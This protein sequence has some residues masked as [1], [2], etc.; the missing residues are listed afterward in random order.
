MISFDLNPLTHSAYLLIGVF[1]GLWLLFWAMQAYRRGSRMTPLRGPPSDSLLFGLGKDTRASPDNS[2]IFV[3]WAKE[4][5]SVYRV[6][7]AL[8]SSRVILADP[9]AVAA[10]YARETSIYVRS[11]VAR[12]GMERLVSYQLS[13]DVPPSCLSVPCLTSDRA[14]SNLG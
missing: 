4:Y 10:F 9:K 12:R 14:W 1:F 5:G 13:Y 6:P 7:A 11:S 2:A 3:Q 8:G